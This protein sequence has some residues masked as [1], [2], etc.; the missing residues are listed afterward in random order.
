[1]ADGEQILGVDVVRADGHE[2]TPRL[3]LA[4]V[5]KEGKVI[6][7]GAGAEIDMHAGAELARTSSAFTLSWSDTGPPMR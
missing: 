5:D 7:E 1:M 4:A 6:N 2:I 3:I